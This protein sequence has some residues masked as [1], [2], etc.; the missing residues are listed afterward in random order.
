[1]KIATARMVAQLDVRLGTRINTNRLPVKS[2][3]V[4]P[5]FFYTGPFFFAQR[6]KDSRENEEKDESFHFHFWS[7]DVSFL[8]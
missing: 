5:P 8:S 3:F 4:P 7:A 1:M 6:T 2:A